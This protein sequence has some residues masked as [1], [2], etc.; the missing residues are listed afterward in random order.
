DWDARMVRLPWGK[1]TPLSR[2]SVD[3]AGHWLNHKM[4]LFFYLKMLGH[5]VNT[6]TLYMGEAPAAKA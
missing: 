3:L 5:P 2:V 1:P 4:Q 6:M